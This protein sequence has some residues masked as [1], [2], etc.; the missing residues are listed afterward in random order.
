[1]ATEPSTPEQDQVHGQVPGYVDGSAPEY[2][3]YEVLK[4]LCHNNAQFFKTHDN[5]TGL[6]LHGAF[7]ALIDHVEAVKPAVDFIRRAA[8]SFDFDESTPGNGYASFVS[9]V[10]ACIR[11]GVKLCK[12]VCINRDSFFFRASY[13]MR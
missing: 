1:M 11:H 9:V 6:R 10:D 2:A 7:L 3:L 8:A 13:Y 4:D 12:Q 5:E